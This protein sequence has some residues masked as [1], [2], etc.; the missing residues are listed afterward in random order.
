MAY[1]TGDRL[2]PWLLRQKIGQGGFGRVFLASNGNAKRAAVKI[3]SGDEGEVADSE[4]RLRFEQ[5]LELLK[6]LGTGRTARVIDADVHGRP[7]W[8]ATEFI[9]GQSLQAEISHDGPLKG[10]LW[11]ELAFH[12]LE[13]LDQAHRKGII[14]RDIKPGNIMRAARGSVIIDFGASL[15]LNTGQDRITRDAT[16]M[17]VMFASPEQL[18]GHDVSE[19]T[20]L[21]SAGL[22]LAFAALGRPLFD[23]QSL[24]AVARKILEEEPDYSALH[25]S[26]SKFLKELLVK[27]SAGRPTA[28]NARNLAEK[29]RLEELNIPIARSIEPPP[30]VAGRTVSKAARRPIRDG[31]NEAVWTETRPG[32]FTVVH[33]Y[34]NPWG[35]TEQPSWDIFQ[36]HIR[37]W[38][39]RHSNFSPGSKRVS[40]L[41][42]GQTEEYIAFRL[43]L[44]ETDNLIAHIRFDPVAPTDPVTTYLFESMGWSQPDVSLERWERA[45]PA[46]DRTRSTRLEVILT[47][48]RTALSLPPQKILLDTSPG[49]RSGS[50]RMNKLLTG[51]QDP[52]FMPNEGVW[53]QGEP[54]AGYYS[55]KVNPDL[56]NCLES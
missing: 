38:F 26:Q 54:D 21:F 48:T 44:G 51:S 28:R 15:M 17:T 29:G 8:I 14:H 46:K 1:Q 4:T 25:P 40:E 47:T 22:T 2:G 5:E 32:K 50:Y 42:A 7:P 10:N 34:Q 39:K 49:L 31:S 16:P 45:I 56:W 27:D 30:R 13:G 12:L 20:D 55:I 53:H 9:A 41:I 35:E 19:A 43:V 11:W 24:G 37:S 52:I 23:G 33:E 36:E 3:L 18:L 6:K